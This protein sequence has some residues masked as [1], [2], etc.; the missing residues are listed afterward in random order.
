MSLETSKM[1]SDDVLETSR[2]SSCLLQGPQLQFVSCLCPL[3]IFWIIGVPRHCLR[4][5]IV[6]ADELVF[7]LS[8][9]L[10]LSIITATLGAEMMLDCLILESEALYEMK[11]GPDWR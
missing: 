10:F 11:K 1:G 7:S 5:S 4:N 8:L 6:G 9:S 3:V 2:Y